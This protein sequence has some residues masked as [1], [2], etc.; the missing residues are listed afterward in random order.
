MNPLQNKNKSS[1]SENQ[2]DRNG[3]EDK[4]KGWTHRQTEAEWRGITVLYAY[5]A[6]LVSY[7]K[8]QV[9]KTRNKVS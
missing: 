7:T 2:R 4:K 1:E 6:S 8:Q 9:T 5:W 3:G